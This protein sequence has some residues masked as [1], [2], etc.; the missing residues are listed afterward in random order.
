[1]QWLTLIFVKRKELIMME[2][3]HKFRYINLDRRECIKCGRQEYLNFTEIED[4]D[5]I[6]FIPRW[7]EMPATIDLK[8]MKIFVDNKQ[9]YPKM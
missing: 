7:E 4:S 6:R 8:S 5:P 3:K 9:V 1:M 2:C